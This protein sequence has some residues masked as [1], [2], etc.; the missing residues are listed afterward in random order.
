MFIIYKVYTNKTGIY[1][2]ITTTYESLKFFLN[3]HLI[4]PLKTIY[5]STFES[6]SSESAYENSQ[7]NYTNSKKILE[8]MLEEYGRQHAGTLAQVNNISVEEFLAT[9]N[10]RAR[11]EDMNVVMKNYQQELNSPIR[12]ALLGDLIK[13]I[14][15]KLIRSID[16]HVCWFRYIDSSTKSQ[17]R[18]RRFNHTN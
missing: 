6:R 16:F 10:E 7:L 17:S 1:N 14:H 18:W 15:S 13:G 8:E 11:N 9:L 12:S 5:T 3:E 2:Y 4:T